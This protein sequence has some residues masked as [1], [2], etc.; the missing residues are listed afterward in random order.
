[1][2]ARTAPEVDI[3]IHDLIDP[4]KCYDFLRK[5]RWPHGTCCPECTSNSVKKN[6]HKDSD[7]LCQKYKCKN[8]GCR[9]GSS[10]VS[11]CR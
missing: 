2:I 5:K 8:C 4:A 11:G 9:F 1:M 10:C 3:R 6:G 7:P